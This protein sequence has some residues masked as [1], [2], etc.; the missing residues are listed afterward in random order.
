LRHKLNLPVAMNFFAAS[1]GANTPIYKKSLAVPGTKRQK[2]LPRYHPDWPIKQPALSARKSFS[3]Y[4]GSRRT[5][6]LGGINRF[7]RRLLGNEMG[8]FSRRTDFH[9]KRRLSLTTG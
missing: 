3:A 2:R 6:L 7:S 1:G 8:I 4:N 5:K 9:R